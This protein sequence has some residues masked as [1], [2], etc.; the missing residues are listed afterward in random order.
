MSDRHFLYVIGQPG[1][2][3]ST[4][5]KHLVAA[6]RAKGQMV[7]HTKPVAH[8]TWEGEL[9]H[10]DVVEIGGERDT[11]RGTDATPM[12]VQPA[13]IKFVQSH[14][15]NLMMAEGD[16]LA[17]EGFFQAVM[18]AGYRLTVF[19]LEVPDNVC[20]SRRN[21]RAHELGV[22]GQAPAW[23]KGRITKV[24]NLAAWAMKNA[25]VYIGDDSW[26][27]DDWVATLRANGNVIARVLDPYDTRPVEFSDVEFMEKEADAI[28]EDAA[29]VMA[30]D[31]RTAKKRSEPPRKA[32]NSGSAT[33][34]AKKGSMTTVAPAV[35]SL[36]T[37]VPD[38]E[39]DKLKGRTPTDEDYDLLL[40]GPS[41]VYLPGKER[42]MQGSKAVEKRRLL[43][44][45]LPGVL[46]DVMDETYDVL[47]TIRLATDNRGL[48]SGSPRVQVGTTRTRHIPILSG[49]MGAM[50]P[51]GP[52]QYCRLTAFTAQQVEK[53]DKLLPLWQAMSAQFQEHVPH[54]FKNQVA[55]AR[56]TPPEWVIKGTPFTT[57]TIN[58][59]YSTGMHT[60][61]G[62]LDEGFSCLAV[63]RKGEYTGGRLVFPQWR[64]AADMQHGDMILMDA[65]Q[66][67]G[68]TRMECAC[69]EHMHTGPCK[70]CEAERIS[71]VAYYRTKMKNCG[72]LAE[73]SERKRAFAERRVEAGEDALTDEE[74]H[75]ADLDAVTTQDGPV[76]ASA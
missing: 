43:C 6:R 34:P 32:V 60:D 74:Q 49:V 22:P 4:L 11:F 45:Y 16:R 30:G 51:V 55:H 69:G 33:T 28:A 72:T 38:S 63:A 26:D 12:N 66:W 53:W 40:E 19:H 31:K 35:H 24:K 5:V 17:T 52:M 42:F 18:D 20:E 56:R 48:A 75:A 8:I 71:V 14:P 7:P 50:D 54:R 41:T 2:G 76:P 61:K 73:E 9:G 10:G 29:A 65:H 46:A 58:N 13:A 21:V 44:I 25:D 1:A 57:I 37:R 27:V 3:K 15:A 59:S 36:S 23:V 64:V 68:N 67:H 70:E 62:D 39:L 47:T